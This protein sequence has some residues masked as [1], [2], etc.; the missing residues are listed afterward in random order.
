MGT[1]RTNIEL[2]DDMIERAMAHPQSLDTP[3]EGASMALVS[4]ED[5]GGDDFRAKPRC[6]PT[7]RWTR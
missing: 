4:V 5:E 7:R 1:T 6:R 2:D 3:M